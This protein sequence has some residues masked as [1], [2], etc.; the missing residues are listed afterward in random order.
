MSE[1]KRISTLPSPPSIPREFKARTPA[2]GGTRR[3][4]GAMVLRFEDAL[5]KLNSPSKHIDEKRA[6]VRDICT[7]DEKAAA[8]PRPITIADSA[9]V[10]PDTEPE[11][12]EKKD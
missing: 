6:E 1:S 11:E 12:E 10:I 7:P 8:F 2:P 9:E 4:S 5:N 3:L